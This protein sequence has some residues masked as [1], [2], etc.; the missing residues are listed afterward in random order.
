MESMGPGEG[1][2]GNGRLWFTEKLV[3]RSISGTGGHSPLIDFYF[4]FPDGSRKPR[5]EFSQVEII[6][7][8][9]IQ[10][11][12]TQAKLLFPLQLVQLL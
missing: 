3:K 10:T 7:T 1:C 11:Q 6:L 2:L 4:Y 9:A 5:Q 8:L 12:A